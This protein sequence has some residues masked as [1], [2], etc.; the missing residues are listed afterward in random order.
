MAYNKKLVNRIEK[1]F[2]KKNI[3]ADGK[4]FMGGY[5]FFLDEKMCVGLD[6]DKHTN[7]DRLRARVGPDAME[8]SL[9]RKGC[10]PMDITGRPMNGFVF[11]DPIGFKSAKDLEHWVQVCIDHNPSAKS[12]KKK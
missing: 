5:C 6:I 1:V 2:L 8:D 10:R 12:S 4:K 3:N 9:K 7:Q 11:V